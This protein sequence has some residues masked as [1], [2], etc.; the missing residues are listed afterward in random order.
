MAKTHYCNTSEQLTKSR[1]VSLRQLAAP[2]TAKWLWTV[3]STSGRYPSLLHYS[4]AD[5][6]VC[7][8]LGDACG[9]YGSHSEKSKRHA[10]WVEK[11]GKK[12]ALAIDFFILFQFSIFFF[13][14]LYTHLP[15]PKSQHHSGPTWGPPAQTALMQCQHTMR[16]VKAC[17]FGDATVSCVFSIVVSFSPPPPP[18]QQPRLACPAQKAMTA[19]P[20][21]AR[22]RA[23]AQKPTTR[24]PMT[25]MFKSYCLNDLSPPWGSSDPTVMCQLHDF[26]SR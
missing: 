1:E 26:K 22:A 4:C 19:S 18:A 5:P 10:V 11:I 12:K 3:C 16:V 24:R 17:R 2:Q 13:N 23:S 25:Q 14:V 15:S 20:L 6:L 7:Q 21:K 8:Q 9:M